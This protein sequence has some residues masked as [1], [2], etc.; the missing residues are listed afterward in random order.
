MDFEKHLL[1]YLNKDEIKS[2]MSSLNLKS[3][4]AVLINE[5][6]MSKEMF[7][8]NFPNVNPHPFIKNA[9]IYDKD[10]YQ[11]GKHIFHNLGAYYL[12]EPS[13][14]MPAFLL[15]ANQDDLILDLCAAPGGKTIQTSFLMNNKGLIVSNDL[16]FERS[17][18]IKDNIERLG[19][20]NVLIIS[21]DFSKIYHQYKNTFDKIILD[22]PCSGSGMFRKHELMNDDWSYNKVLKNQAI[23]KEL[24]EYCYKMLKPGGVLMYSTCSFSY[25]EDE[26]VVEHLLTIS[27]AELLSIENN[28]LFYKSKAN[29]GVHLFPHIFPGEGHY[30]CLI[31]KPGEIKK[32]EIL[33]KIN[34]LIKK[35][36]LSSE[37]SY[38]EKYNNVVFIHDRDFLLKNLSIVRYGVKVGEILPK[39]IKYDL[40]YARYITTFINEINLDEQNT[41][42]YLK[43]N[44]LEIE[45]QKGYILLKYKGIN[46]DIAKS[47]GRLIKNRYP[48][49]LRIR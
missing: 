41:M 34:L 17:K 11:L 37:Y 19:I 25:E 45:T 33:E 29:I 21:N 5:Q 6:K 24:I 27:E 36:N 42:S 7:L 46:I 16:S 8:E 10:E 35:Y 18:A 32:K 26:E 13:A 15:N 20:G 49:Y 1:K 38:L 39:E 30:M 23:Q 48:K 12:Q 31:K 9:F 43:G 14:M 22:A 44:P 28:P 47:D 3:K 2:L 4:H 40:H